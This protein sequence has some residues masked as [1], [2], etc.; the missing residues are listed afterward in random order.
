[1]LEFGALTAPRA[2]SQSPWSRTCGSERPLP[3]T[4]GASSRGRWR[5]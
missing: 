2:G 1:M 5:L 3:E 4:C